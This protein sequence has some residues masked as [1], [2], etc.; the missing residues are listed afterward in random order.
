[1]QFA[2]DVTLFALPDLDQPAR[3]RLQLLAPILDLFKELSIDKRDAHLLAED[4]EELRLLR[5][6]RGRRASIQIEN[7]ARLALKPQGHLQ[8]I[9][10]GTLP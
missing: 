10:A 2:G 5:P 4:I 6:E 7:A 8:P 1:M 9:E 3:D